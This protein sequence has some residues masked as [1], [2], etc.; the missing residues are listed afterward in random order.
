LGI[1]PNELRFHEEINAGALL[2]RKSTKYA[3][4]AL[5]KNGLDYLSKA[6]RDHKITE[7]IVVLARWEG[8]KQ[9]VVCIR[10]VGEVVASLEGVPP[11]DGPLGP[12]WWMTADL[13]PFRR[14]DYAPVRR[15]DY[16]PF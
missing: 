16:V 7:A 3:E 13:T 12:Y 14:E 15:D 5:S 8:A 10:P 2:V 11:R 4:Y 1:S 9:I 6:L